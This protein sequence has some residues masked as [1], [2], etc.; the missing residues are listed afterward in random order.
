M[1]LIEKSK[2]YF[3]TTTLPECGGFILPSG[4]MLNFCDDQFNKIFD[5]SEISAVLAGTS[6]S[7]YFNRVRQFEN[8]T[9]SV[10]LFKSQYRDSLYFEFVKPLTFSQREVLRDAADLSATV[11]FDVIGSDGKILESDSGGARDK[12]VR[13]VVRRAFE[14]SRRLNAKS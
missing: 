13:D 3:G 4:E 9:G 12:P 1:D 14:I 8:E 5:H 6:D 2:K 7:P 11:T 10:R